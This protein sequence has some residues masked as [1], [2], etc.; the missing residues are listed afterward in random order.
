M[1]I[2]KKLY[3]LNQLI[4]R[5]VL[6]RYRGAMF[7]LIWV[8]L[9]PI[10]IMSIFAFVFGEIFQTRWPQ[11]G[12]GSPFWL[13]LYAG[14]IAFNFFSESV[15]RA[16]SSVRSFPSYVKKIIFPLEILPI[17]PVGAAL[18]HFAFNCLILLAALVLTGNFTQS[19]FLYPLLLLPLLLLST[20]FS[21]FFAAWG[22]FIKDM[23]QIITPLLQ[24]LMYLSPVLY[25]VSA[26]PT[27]LQFLYKANPIGVVIDSCRNAALGLPI[28]WGNW[29]ISLLTGVFFAYFGLRFF[30]HSCE[31]FADVI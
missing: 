27:Y 9:N 24:I 5:D 22:V 11:Q 30:R 31:E 26:I 18:V 23:N 19:V 15:G 8:L 12:V 21:F 14:L 28:D 20:G 2:S 1:K 17:V 7:G 6:L 29:G 13:I 10:I 25:P 3:L 4:L 16:P